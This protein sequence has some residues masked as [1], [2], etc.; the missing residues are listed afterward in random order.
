M[1]APVYF[2]GFDCLGSGRIWRG[3]IGE[4]GDCYL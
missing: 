2:G 3:D 4:G 1:K